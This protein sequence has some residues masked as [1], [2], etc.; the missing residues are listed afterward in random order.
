VHRA[1]GLT[2]DAVEIDFQLD[3]WWTAGRVH[4][5][6]S[7]AR[8]FSFLRVQGLRRDLIDASRSAVAYYAKQLEEGNID[9]AED[10]RPPIE[11]SVGT[12][13]ALVV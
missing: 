12:D 10:R 8:S 6:L 1:L 7:W 2:L 9:P 5:A 13:T 11:S 4:T 3:S